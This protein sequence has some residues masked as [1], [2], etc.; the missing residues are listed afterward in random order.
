MGASSRQKTL[1]A[2]FWER[3][4]LGKYPKERDDPQYLLQKPL[5]NVAQKGSHNV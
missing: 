5:Q 2:L 1:V 3:S 4:E